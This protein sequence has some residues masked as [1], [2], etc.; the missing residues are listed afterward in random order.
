MYRQKNGKVYY[1]FPGGSIKPNESKEAAAIRE[2]FEETSIIG[3]TPRLLYHLHIK[4]IPTNYEALFGYKDEF[5]FLCN[6]V[7]GN[8]DLAADSEEHLRSSD[9]NFYKP[10]WVPIDQLKDILL[11]PLEIRDLLITDIES[12][13]RQKTLKIEVSNSKLRHL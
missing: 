11:Y 9:N 4:D 2:L 6:Y 3:N 13:L 12:G 10:M 5:L 1:V 8:P 7:S